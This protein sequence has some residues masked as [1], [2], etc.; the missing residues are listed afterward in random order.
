MS[1]IT[2]DIFISYRRL[3]S[4][5]FC[6][7]LAAELRGVFGGLSVFIDTE[8]IRD[9]EEWPTRI[10][11]ALV[12]ARLAL[13]V[14]GRSWL[15]ISDDFGRRRIDNPGDWVRREI[16]VSLN[17]KVKII[18][19]LIDDAKPL[20][21]EALP[22]SIGKLADLE[23]RTI[24]IKH[25]SRDVS[26]F[27]DSIGTFLG[28]KKARVPI[29]YPAALLIINPLDQ[30]NLRKFDELNADWMV[31]SRPDEQTQTEKIELVR[32]YE[33]MSFEDAI[34]FMSTAARFIS[35]KNHHPEWSNIWRTV[36][37]RLTSWDI[38]HKPSMLDVDVAR[39]LDLLYTNYLPK[40][41]AETIDISAQKA[42]AENISQDRL[43]E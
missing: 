31:T 29:P 23:V 13:V 35:V 43:K 7:W 30:D 4:A 15:S 26:E 3:D 12:G 27:V 16:E 19:V 5:I 10:E 34:H 2:C 20:A 40:I 1:D 37:V 33:F 6:Q 25:I 39:Y 17:K 18:P 32:G 36:V 28:R 42:A 11:R 22:P 21:A 8:S 38:G 41:T 9:G 14:I 24:D